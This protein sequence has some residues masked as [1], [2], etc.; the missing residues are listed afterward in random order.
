VNNKEQQRTTKN[1]VNEEQD[2]KR[3][4]LLS[5]PQFPTGLIGE[6]LAI[7][8]APNRVTS[9]VPI[10]F[11]FNTIRKES[12]AKGVPLTINVIRIQTENFTLTVDS[13]HDQEIR[14]LH[15]SQEYEVEI[16]LMLPMSSNHSYLN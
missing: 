13:P 6:F 14:H 2:Q 1:K 11:I 7:A 12:I 8:A 15:C 5:T 4:F 16:P 3:I 9:K 10:K